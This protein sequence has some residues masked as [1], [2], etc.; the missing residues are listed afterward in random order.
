MGKT[1]NIIGA[2][3]VGQTLGHLWQRQQTFVI[4]DVLN[5]TLLSAQTAVDFMQAGRATLDWSTLRAADVWMITVRDDQIANAAN[6]L[7]D[8]GLLREGDIVFH[9]SGALPSALLVKVQDHGAHIASVHP[10]KSF[11]DPAIA[12]TNFAGT[13]C[14]IEGDVAAT[15]VLTAAFT[16]LDA[17]LIPINASQKTLYHGASVVVSN[18][19]VAL[20]EVGIQSFIQAGISRED[21]LKIIAPIATG[22]IHNIANLGTAHALTGPIARGDLPTVA[23]QL[24]AF[25]HW[26]ADFGE[27]YRLLGTVAV[28]LA[29]D[30][31]QANS[32]HLRQIQD[33]LTT[34]QTESANDA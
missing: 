10:I 31:A 14:G 5:Q 32:V 33:L 18:Y 22:T 4:Q 17:H 11:A 9:C 20:M 25:T 1:L 26:Q 23:K 30:K 13:F 24:K 29:K 27:L 7:A 3:H 8:S 12:V 19:L 21:T 16:T 2:G 15:T 28:T 34:P 6:Q